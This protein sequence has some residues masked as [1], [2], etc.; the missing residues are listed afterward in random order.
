[1]EVIDEH[2]PQS[3]PPTTNGSNNGVSDSS[4]NGATKA[5]RSSADK[6][7]DVSSPPPVV[8]GLP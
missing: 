2:S 4:G 5:P 3:A 8:N 1:M 6:T 7:A